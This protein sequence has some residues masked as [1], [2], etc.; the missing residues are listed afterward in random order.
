M[1]ADRANAPDASDPV[2]MVVHLEDLLLLRG[3]VL[4]LLCI[5]VLLSV[6]HGKSHS[7]RHEDIIVLVG[8]ADGPVRRLYLGR[9]HVVVLV[10]RL[11]R[12]QLILL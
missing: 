5:L 11:Q 7:A 9:V 6:H 1:R 12:L 4:V 10:D 3:E 8:A 2:R